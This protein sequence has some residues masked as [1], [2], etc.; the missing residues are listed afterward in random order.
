MMTTGTLYSWAMFTQPLL[1]AFDWDVT[2][3]TWAYALANFCLAAIGAVIGGFWQDGVGPRRVAATGVILWGAGNLAAGLGMTHFGALWLYLTYGAVGGVG[4]GMA[5]IAPISMVA[6]WFP[7]RRGVAGGVVAAGFGLGAFIYNELVSRLPA[8][9]AVA[10]RAGAY[11]AAN[12]AAAASGKPID[13]S[14]VRAGGGPE[15]D[16]RCDNHAR[17]RWLGMRLSCRGS[18][19]RLSIS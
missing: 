3:T 4:A 11:L 2:T 5:Y 14:A 8:F 15:P 16:G 10:S 18:H 9:H 1:V 12:A 17:I 19:F 6:K 13:A 7:G